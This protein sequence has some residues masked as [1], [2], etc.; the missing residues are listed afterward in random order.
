M[1]ETPPGR[2]PVQ[3]FFDG[4]PAPDACRGRS[5]PGPA[6]CS[7]RREAADDRPRGAW[8]RPAHPAV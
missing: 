3:D 6:R 5:H 7:H 1:F 8:L 2:R 4:L